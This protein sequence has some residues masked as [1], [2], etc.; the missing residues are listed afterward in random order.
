MKS[1]ISTNSPTPPLRANNTLRGYRT[2]WRDWCTWSNATGHPTLPATPAGISRYLTALAKSGVTVGTM[3]R[4]IS[5]IRFAHR[6]RNLDD[7]TRDARVRTV[8]EGIRRTHGA[9]PAQAAPLMPPELFVVLD[10]CPTVRRFKT[11]GRADEPNLAGARDRALLLVGFTAALRRSELAALRVEHLAEHPHGLVISIPRSKTNQHG[12]KS[13]LV[14]LPREQP[15]ALSRHGSSA[16]ARA[17][18]HHHRSGPA[19][20]DQGK[21]ARPKCAQRRDRQS[22]G[23]GG[24]P[25]SRP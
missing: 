13:E 24:D 12:L 8:W 17:R 5:S 25:A 23:A 19:S 11:R 22:A 21:P 1:L 2:D 9:P 10:A 7:P 6:V 18:R 4:R 16:L 20:G 15:G 3:G 14:V